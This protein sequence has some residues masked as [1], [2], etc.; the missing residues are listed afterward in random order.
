MNTFLEYT[1]YNEEFGF[2][3]NGVKYEVVS[4]F[5][6][7]IH[8]VEGNIL[9]QSFKNNEQL[10]ENATIEGLKLSSILDKIIVDWNICIIFNEYMKFSK[11]SLENLKWIL[12][13]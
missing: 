7:Y 8:K 4:E 2:E 10:L 12:L 5:G 3:Y 6:R 11:S 13:Y 1:S 9:I